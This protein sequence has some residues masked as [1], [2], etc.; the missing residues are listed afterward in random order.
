MGFFKGFSVLFVLLGG[1]VWYF[2]GFFEWFCLGFLLLMSG[3]F[4]GGGF[5]SFLDIFLSHFI[6]KM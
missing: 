2:F 5:F 4:G 6:R 3:F 1:L